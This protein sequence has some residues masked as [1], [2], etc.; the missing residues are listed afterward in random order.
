MFVSIM[1]SLLSIKT[2]LKKVDA[3]ASTFFVTLSQKFMLVLVIIKIQNKEKE[4]I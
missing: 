2:N 3:N 1:I 4:K